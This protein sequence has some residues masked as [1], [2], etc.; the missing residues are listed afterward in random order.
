[1]VIGTTR[2]YNL[3]QFSFDTRVALIDRVL[4][5]EVVVHIETAQDARQLEGVCSS[6]ISCLGVL[7]VLGLSG[8]GTHG[9]SYKGVFVEVIVH[10]REYF[11]WTAALVTSTPMSLWAASAVR[12]VHYEISK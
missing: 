4:E 1:M 8:R 7:G 3:A 12:S 9:E 11:L 10:W 2:S 6:L 5:Y